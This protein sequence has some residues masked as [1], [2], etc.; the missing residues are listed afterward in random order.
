MYVSQDTL[1]SSQMKLGC[2]EQLL[3][4]EANEKPNPE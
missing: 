1:L 3:S 4:N 2:V